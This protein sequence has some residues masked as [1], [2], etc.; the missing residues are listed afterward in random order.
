MANVPARPIHG[1]RRGLARPPVNRAIV[2]FI[3]IATLY[4]ARDILIPLAFAVSLAFV[5]TPCVTALRKIHIGRIPAAVLTI[6]GAVVLLMGF[7]WMISSQLIEVAN[8]LPQYRANIH[9]KI[10]ALRLPST[11]A[12][13]QA[14][15]SVREVTQEFTDGPRTAAE[16]SNKAR[17]PAPVEI[18]QPPANELAYLRDLVRPFLKPLAETGIVLIFCIFILIE[19]EDLRNRLLRLAGL[20]QLNVMTKAIDDAAQRVSRYL[21]MQLLVNTC[22]GTLFGIGLY[23]IGVP[24]ALLWGVVA[25]MFRIVPY[26]GTV[27]AAALPFILSLAVFDDWLRPLLVFVLFSSLELVTGNLIEPM[28]YGVHTGISSLALLVSAVF[29]TAVWGPAGLILSTPLTVCLVVIGRYAPQLAFLHIMLGDEQ[30][31]AAEAQLY[32]RLLAMDQEEARAVVD[33]FLKDHTLADLYDQVLIPAMSMAE[34]DRHRGA[35]EAEREEF[36]YL[37]ISEMV[38]EFAESAAA[39]TVP[40]RTTKTRAF[41]LPAYDQA[42]E[43]SCAMLAQL[44]EQKGMI[45][46]AFPAGPT[47]DEMFAFIQPEAGD[48]V[49]I[50]AVPPYAFTPAKTM[51]NHLRNRFPHSTIIVGIWGFSGDIQKAMARF[52]RGKPDRLFATLDQ[53]VNEVLGRETGEAIQ[54]EIPAPAEMR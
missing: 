15:E 17:P 26:A 46:M 7:A 34:Q 2:F 23:F 31:L 24:N 28:L 51:V 39:V 5:L 14:A 50:S 49:C 45:A 35:I 36:L 37:N 21:L 54:P 41:C 30:V 3:T 40:T 44:L 12:L 43:I 9:S 52:D 42:D 27:I 10:E 16:A 22:F 8:Q 6:T 25:A 19:R 18:V 29:W 32:Q 53:V 47:A 4:F 48:V 13:G 33:L 20:S 38:A 11:G 1:E